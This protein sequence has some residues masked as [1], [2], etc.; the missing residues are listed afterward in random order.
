MAMSESPIVTAD[1]YGFRATTW[2]TRQRVWIGA[3]E[4]SD[5]ITTGNLRSAVGDM[6][7]AEFVLTKGLD[8]VSHV[9]FSALVIVGT[10][11]SEANRRFTGYV[12]T[13]R[14]ERESLTIEC[15][16]HP[17]LLE[18][19]TGA[20]ASNGAHLD[21][22]YALARDAGLPGHRIQIDDTADVPNELFEV[23]VPLVGV[24]LTSP[25]HIGSVSFLTGRHMPDIT[26]AVANQALVEKWRSSSTYAVTYIQ[27]RR[28]LD[29]EELGRR[30]IFDAVA[31]VNV[32]RRYSNLAWPDGTHQSW[33][34]RHFRE[35]L[36]AT[37][38]TRVRGLV[39]Q[40]SWLREPGSARHHGVGEIS[41]AVPGS[42]FLQEARKGLREAITSA[43]RAMTSDDPHVRITAISECLEFYAGSVRTSSRI[44]GTHRRAITR[45]AADWPEEERA[46]LAQ[47]LEASGSAPLLTRVRLQITKD[48]VPVRD[49][50]LDA[51]AA[52]RK[53]RND[54]VH[55]KSTET[56]ASLDLATALLARML[57][58]A[59]YASRRSS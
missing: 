28:M 42:H 25:E 58:Y 26:A 41:F 54:L 10:D 46:A 3:H 32:A 50:E 30:R 37:D 40:R 34:R 24:K 59:I 55:G 39:S 56:T 33:S 17:E 20:M 16:S 29:A 36:R 44:S 45:M 9:D 57:V 21:L 38:L 31:W 13:S 12:R 8:L 51:L 23:V 53:M 6:A 43:E 7:R 19:T 49:D 22:V 14:W 2:S 1:P 18:N 5:A 27:S 48:G 35:T 15:V 11:R 47:L 52:V 4:I